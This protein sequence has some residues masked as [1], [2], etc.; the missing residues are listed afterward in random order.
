MEQLF[1]EL[2]E[3]YRD[4]DMNICTKIC[5]SDINFF[6]F[7]KVKWVYKSNQKH[8]LYIILYLIFIVVDGDPNKTL[9]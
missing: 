8:L 3:L 4:F 2:F 6:L 5:I 1:E 7:S 9:L